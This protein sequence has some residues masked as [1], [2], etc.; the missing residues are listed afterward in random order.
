LGW[1]ACDG[2]RYLPGGVDP[3]PRARGLEDEATERLAPLHPQVSDLPGEATHKM[4]HRV[5]DSARLDGLDE[6]PAATMTPWADSL[7]SPK[8]MVAVQT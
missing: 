7:K 8:L 1:W 6:G 3:D 2:R 4:R 5:A